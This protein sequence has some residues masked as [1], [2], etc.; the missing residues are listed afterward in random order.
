MATY[1]IKVKR[2]LEGYTHDVYG[3]RGKELGV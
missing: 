1:I 2:G 3:E